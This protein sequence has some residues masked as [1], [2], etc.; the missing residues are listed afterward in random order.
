MHLAQLNIAESLAPLDDPLL[1]EFV[2]NLD[3]INDLAEQSEGFVWRLKGDDQNDA[4]EFV[5]PSF[6]NAIVNMSVWQTPEALKHYV[7]KTAHVDFLKRKKE[8]FHKLRQNHVVLWWVEEGHTPTL[9]EA[10]QKL[11]HLRDHGES[12]E[13]FTFAFLAKQAPGSR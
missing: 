3:R 2:D 5:L 12:S 13:A 8:W 6:P 9:E 7:Y 4:T 11:R 1:K 10:D